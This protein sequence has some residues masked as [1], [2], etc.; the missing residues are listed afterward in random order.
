MTHDA[1]CIFCKIVAG[2]IPCFKI[3]EDA[4]VLSFMDIAPFN[5]GHCLVITKSHASDIFAADP[6]DLAAVARA[7]Q[8]VAAAVNQAMQPPGL[9]IL[10]ANGPAAGQSV[11]HYHC[12]VF[13][14]RQGDS[15]PLNWPHTPGDMA[16]IEDNYKKIMAAMPR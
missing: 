16:R 5:D 9:N 1:D 15:A 3:Y 2:E 10:Q 13:P 11:F 14:R 7:V 12:H 8:L 6:E 4:Q